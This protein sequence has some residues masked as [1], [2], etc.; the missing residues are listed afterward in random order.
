MEKGSGL[1][2]STAWH[3]SVRTRLYF[4]A[5]SGNDYDSKA[6]PDLRELQCMKSN[7]GPTGEIIRLRWDNGTFKPLGTPSSQERMAEDK[8]TEALFL[9]LLDRFN[10]QGQRVSPHPSSPQ[11]Y[12]PKAF[13]NHA[14]ANGT[15]KKPFADAMQRLLDAGTIRIATEGSPSKPVTRLMRT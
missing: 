10:R 6:D 3:N 13:A 15:G 14:E 7:Y 2:G 5:A 11:N 9:E 12:A 4:K 8:K 1:S